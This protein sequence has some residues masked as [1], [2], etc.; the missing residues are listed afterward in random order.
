M[1]TVLCQ[2]ILRF[3]NQSVW[4]FLNF[5]G[6]NFMAQSWTSRTEVLSNWTQQMCCPAHNVLFCLFRKKAQLFFH[7]IS[8]QLLYYSLNFIH[9]LL[10]IIA[11]VTTVTVLMWTPRLVITVTRVVKCVNSAEIRDVQTL[12][13]GS[14]RR[15]TD[16]ITLAGMKSG[17]EQLLTDICWHVSRTSNFHLKFSFL[18]LI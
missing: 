4:L 14:L 1:A 10:K 18:R 9:G 6:K 16:K 2:E 13:D 11:S 15:K 3:S 5:L 7:F 8:S 12:R 17:L